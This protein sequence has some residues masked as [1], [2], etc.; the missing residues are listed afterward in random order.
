M[1]ILITGASGLIGQEIVKILKENKDFTLIL[2]SREKK[3]G[4]YT[5]D[6]LDLI[7][8]KFKEIDAVIN[9]AGENIGNKLWSKPQKQIII[10]SRLSVIDWIS[11]LSNKI[12]IKKVIS[13]SAIGFYKKNLNEILTEESPGSKDFL[14]NVCKSWEERLDTIKTDKI[15]IIRTGVVLSPNCGALKKMILPFKLGIGGII[16]NGHQIMSW[17]SLNDIANLYIDL[18]INDHNIKIINGVANSCSNKEFTKS[19]GSAL[20]R[21][22]LIP[23]PKFIIN[24]IFG[25]MSSIILDSQ[26]VSSI[27]SKY[28]D[29]NIREYLN[30]ILSK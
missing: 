27:Y 24:L 23:I 5:F 13:S 7:V 12:L 30:K 1:N 6:D 14:G 29:T 26:K 17:I 11:A 16:G 15:Q 28:Q 25:E 20:F 10:K 18:I 8:N 2:L 9:L 21:P 19:L 3:D 22:T 4:Y